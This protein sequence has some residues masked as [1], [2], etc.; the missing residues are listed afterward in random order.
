LALNGAPTSENGGI[1]PLGLISFWPD[2]EF[3]KKIKI[4]FFPTNFF[5]LFLDSSG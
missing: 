4:G 3:S 5:L 2:I 1:G